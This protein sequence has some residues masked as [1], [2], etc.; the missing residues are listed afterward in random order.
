MTTHGFK[1][2]AEDR[3]LCLIDSGRGLSDWTGHK[4]TS[5][6]QKASLSE[7][8]GEPPCVKCPWRVVRC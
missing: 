5:L 8:A 7:D 2:T 4:S 6:P 1:A 3:P